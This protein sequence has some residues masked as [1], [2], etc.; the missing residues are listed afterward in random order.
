MFNNFFK[1]TNTLLFGICSILLLMGCQPIVDQSIADAPTI[2]TIVSEQAVVLQN[3]VTAVPTSS[4]SQTS[5]APWTPIP[6]IAKTMVIG[7]IAFLS[8][9]NTY[10]LTV[11]ITSLVAMMISNNSLNK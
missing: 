5:T 2:E 4:I 11:T 1:L 7:S 9:E 3:T 8:D 6:T 10:L